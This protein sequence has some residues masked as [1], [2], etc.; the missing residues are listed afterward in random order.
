MAVHTACRQLFP[1]VTG[2]VRLLPYRAAHIQD[3]PA[4]RHLCRRWKRLHGA[5]RGQKDEGANENVKNG[6][7]REITG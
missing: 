4:W 5:T 6:V 1:Q 7:D 3:P 2:H